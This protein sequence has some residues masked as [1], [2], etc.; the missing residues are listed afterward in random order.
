M[1]AF[2]L[3]ALRLAKYDIH[4]RI[5]LTKIKRGLMR[6]DRVAVLD[7]PL[8]EYAERIKRIC[9]EMADANC[10]GVMITLYENMR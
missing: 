1:Q 10:D 3:T 2:L 7:F 6:M 5:H 8:E 9:R 4:N